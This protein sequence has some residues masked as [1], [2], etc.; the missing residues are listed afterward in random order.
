MPC[1]LAG[2]IQ[3]TSQRRKIVLVADVTARH[4]LPD[5]ICELFRENPYH[6]LKQRVALPIQFGDG[7][8]VEPDVECDSQHMHQPLPNGGISLLHST[9]CEDID[10]GQNFQSTA[11]CCQN[12]D[13]T[14]GAQST[15]S[16]LQHSATTPSRQGRGPCRSR[17][18]IGNIRRNCICVARVWP[19]G[20][21]PPLMDGTADHDC[22]NFEKSNVSFTLQRSFVPASSSPSNPAGMRCLPRR[23]H[24]SS[25]VPLSVGLPSS[26]AATF[27]QSS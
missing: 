27:V 20:E 16:V 11:F 10:F 3:G 25:G 7:T 9:L 13:N 26:T 22:S 18:P 15:S 4:S 23:K 19:I 8:D 12:T 17:K 21:S 1:E 2:D 14:S 24:P 5:S 6:D